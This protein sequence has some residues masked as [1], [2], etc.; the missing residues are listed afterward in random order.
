MTSIQFHPRDDRFFLAGSLD[1]KLRLWSIP[2]RGVACWTQLSDLITA[3]A[4]SPDG[5]T[6]I[7]G[8]LGGSCQFFS[9]EGMKSLSSMNVKSAHGKNA[10]GSKVTGIEAV[11]YPPGDLNGEVKLIITTNDSRIRVYNF[12]DKS[13]ELKLKGHENQ[14]SQ[15]RASLSDDAKYVICGSEDRKAYIWSTGPPE[16][17]KD[18]RPMEMFEAHSAIVTAA[19]LAPIKTRQLLQASGDPLFELCNPP[20]VTL[21]SR[22]ESRSSSS[23]PTDAILPSDLT[24]QPDSVATD[25]GHRRVKPE[26]TP[27]YL[28]RSSHPNGNIIVTADFVGRIK[29]FRQDCGWKKRSKID[30]WDSSPTFSK[31]ILHRT[32]SVATKASKSPRRDSLNHP[33]SDRILSWRQ[34][35]ERNNTS[36]DGFASPRLTSYRSA[37]PRLSQSHTNRSSKNALSA[38]N[39]P[40]ISTLSNPPSLHKSSLDSS[41][42]IPRSYDGAG[43]DPPLDRDNN[44]LMLRGDASYLFWNKD[45]YAEQARIA[46]A[47]RRRR[48]TRDGEGQ[49]QAPPSGETASADGGS[50]NVSLGAPRPDVEKRGSDVSILSS[51]SDA[52]K[53]GDDKDGEVRCQRC[54]GGNFKA[55]IRGRERERALECL[56]CGAMA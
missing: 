1:S 46:Q 26:E 2:D 55:R 23:L 39:T 40:S 45:T 31:K 50:D 13:L 28:A 29:V 48:R 3:V 6:S 5:K 51:D 11:S 16:K 9:T 22:T 20:P 27:A 35:I 21:V 54:G 15:I 7:A 38:I 25:P 52:E 36:S 24:G 8:C 18:K 33:S 14:Y 19:I 10:K 37:S 12:R 43:F 49:G 30:N 47:L 44:P 53:D 41:S 4:F 42:H 34:S 32:S 56:G 17:D